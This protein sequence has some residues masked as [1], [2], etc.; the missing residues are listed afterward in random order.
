[1][2]ADPIQRPA[3]RGP[4]KRWP[5][6]AAIA[7]AALAVVLV[8]FVARHGRTPWV[9]VGPATI[10]SSVPDTAAVGLFAIRTDDGR[11]SVAALAR[12][13]KRRCLQIQFEIDGQPGRSEALPQSRCR[14]LEIVGR[15]LRVGSA[16]AVRVYAGGKLLRTVRASEL[17]RCGTKRN[18]CA[19]AYDRH[20][21]RL[22]VSTRDRESDEVDRDDFLLPMLRSGGEV[23]AEGD[24]APKPERFG[25]VS[26]MVWDASLRVIGGDDPTTAQAIGALLTRRPKGFSVR[27][28]YDGVDGAEA[29]ADDDGA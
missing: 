7:I 25:T 20:G 1:M 19:I 21:K 29:I 13:L 17:D 8:V 2:T 3:E 10:A 16:Q 12:G 27:V 9:T 5:A 14:K 15:A 18:V 22:E 28:D 24:E 4:P 23:A 26:A 11:L 6:F